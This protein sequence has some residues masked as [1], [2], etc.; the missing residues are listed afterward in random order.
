MLVTALLP[1]AN[2]A[3]GYLPEAEDR[4]LLPQ[5]QSVLDRAANMVSGARLVAV[6]PARQLYSLLAVRAA[7]MSWHGISLTVLE[8]G[9]IVH[10]PNTLAAPIQHNHRLCA[11]LI[12][13]WPTFPSTSLQLRIDVMNE[14]AAHIELLFSSAHKRVRSL[15]TYAQ[16]LSELFALHDAVTAKHTTLVARY[17]RALGVALD[18]PPAD[19]L[20]LELG[21]L[22]HDIGK[23][24]IS[25]DILLKT[26]P[27]AAAEWA[28]IR[29]HPALGEHIIR[30]IPDL[31]P[32]AP[33][34]RHHH[35]RWDGSGYPDRLSSNAIPLGARIV[36]LSDAYEV[37]RSGRAYQER[38]TPQ[39][40]T[41]E[42]FAGSGTQFDPSLLPLLPAITSMDLSI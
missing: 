11:I 28:R 33:I 39:A 14:Y 36:A 18:L 8:H 2:Q 37:M 10:Q 15:R 12:L 24:A 40:T 6:S 5:L 9:E 25:N 3:A 30:L 17:S 16:T 1:V 7:Q 19:L 27:L 38:K 42:L 20:E 23:A 4:D 31:A 22:L 32:I 41:H 34:I 26:D 21:A 35:E 13:H 29:E